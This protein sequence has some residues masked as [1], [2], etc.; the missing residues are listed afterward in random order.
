MQKSNIAFL[1][2]QE[3]ANLQFFFAE[4]DSQYSI[5]IELRVAYSA[6]YLAK[7]S[8]SYVTNVRSAS[9]Q[10]YSVKRIK[11]I[12]TEKRK[13]ETTNK[14]WSTSLLRELV[15]VSLIKPISSGIFFNLMQHTSCL[16]N[17]GLRIRSFI[18]DCLVFIDQ[19]RV[20]VNGELMQS[21]H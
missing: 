10:G 12:F 19:V 11:S 1:I 6:R 8:S 14:V 5:R 4:K 2:L 7:S 9:C 3:M 21:V 13:S 16:L 15:L 17:K 20:E 18:N